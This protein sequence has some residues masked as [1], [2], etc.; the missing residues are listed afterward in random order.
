MAAWRV[1]ADELEGLHGTLMEA[2]PDAPDEMEEQIVEL[3]AI[4][5]RHIAHHLRYLADCEDDAQ[6]NLDQTAP[7]S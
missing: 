3:H 5:L 2:A 1:I 4:S 6:D 7:R